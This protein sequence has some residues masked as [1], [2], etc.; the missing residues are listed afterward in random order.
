[1]SSKNMGILLAINYQQHFCD[2]FKKSWLNL[3]GY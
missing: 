3:I 1:M 2:S